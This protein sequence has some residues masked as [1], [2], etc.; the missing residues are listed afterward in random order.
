MHL[1]QLIIMMNLDK[2]IEGQRMKFSI[3]GISQAVTVNFSP[4]A[5]LEMK[6]AALNNQA[7]LSPGVSDTDNQYSE[8]TS[9]EKIKENS[10]D[11]NNLT[12]KGE[13]QYSLTTAAALLSSQFSQ[14][15]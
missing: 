14:L 5:L 12:N 10:A 1:N 8:I 6:N 13:I 7:S 3:P 11:L 9:S 2:V 4:E 15:L